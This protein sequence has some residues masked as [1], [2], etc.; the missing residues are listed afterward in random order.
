[1][2][3]AVRKIWVYF[4]SIVLLIPCFITLLNVDASENVLEIKDGKNSN[5]IAEL[6]KQAQQ[7]PNVDVEVIG[8]DFS[9]TFTDA[10]VYNSV[11][12]SQVIPVLK[13]PRS[14]GV[15]K[16]E[17]K[18]SSGN[19]KVYLTKNTLNAIKT[20]GIGALGKIIPGGAG[21]LLSGLF[22]II[23]ADSNF[24]HGR[25]FVYQNYRYQYWYN[26]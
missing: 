25:V 22:T 13:V 24:K 21:W 6:L 8:D 20:F 1:M 7:N 3:K 5:K 18:I 14:N 19:F 4:C 23:S 16:I 15:N 10:D 12:E 11:K 26:Q 17:G 2:K 9:I